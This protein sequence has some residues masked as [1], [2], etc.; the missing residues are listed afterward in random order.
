M[1]RRTRQNM[2]NALVWA[3]VALTLS[4][5]AFMVYASLSDYNDLVG[6]HILFMFDNLS[7]SLPQH[8]SDSFISTNSMPGIC[9]ITLRG[10]RF[11]P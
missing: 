8:Q 4:P 11:T 5:V 6:G 7:S 1:K 9:W 3:I 10:W 2:L